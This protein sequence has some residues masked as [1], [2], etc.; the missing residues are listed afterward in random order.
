MENKNLIYF[1]S[2]IK[3]DNVKE[4][5]KIIEQN[6]EFLKYKNQ[7]KENIL[8]YAFEKNSYQIID[9]L[10]KNKNNLQLL[11]DKNNSN[12]NILQY[13]IQKKINIDF[14]LE[15]IKNLNIEQ[16]RQLL[17]SV[18]NQKNNILFLAI[19]YHSYS[20]IISI[21]EE[22]KNFELLSSMKNEKNIYQ[23]N[24]LHFLTLYHN[25]YFPQ[26]VK[27]IDRKMKFEKDD[28]NFSPI[29]IASYKQN[30]ENFIQIYEDNSDFQ[31]ILSFGSYNQDE[32]IMDFLLEQK[33][34]NDFQFSEN[35]HP[36]AIAIIKK[37]IKI[38]PKILKKLNTKILPQYFL[39]L[40]IKNYNFMPYLID[41]IIENYE[42]EKN[43][44]NH[45]NILF[46]SF[47]NLNFEKLIKIMNKNEIN[48]ENEQDNLFKNTIIGKKDMIFKI[49]YL[50]E[51]GLVINSKTLQYLLMLPKNQIE[52]IL[53]KTNILNICPENHQEFINF[54]I[55]YKNLNIEKKELI[56]DQHKKV[57]IEIMNVLTKNCN[58]FNNK[59]QFL[60]I[61]KYLNTFEIS[62]IFFK[63]LY[64]NDSKDILQKI[65]KYFPL[66]ELNEK[67]AIIYEL[68][69][70]TWLH[71]KSDISQYFLKYK[72]VLI[73][74]FLK[75]IQEN[76]IP[77]NEKFIASLKLKKIHFI[78]E[79]EIIN[80]LNSL[81]NIEN[82]LSFIK[83]INSLF[84]EEKL[85]FDKVSLALIENQYDYNIW[86]YFYEKV[87]KQQLFAETF[88]NYSILRKNITLTEIKNFIKKLENKND[89]QKIAFKYCIQD[90]LEI[91]KFN[92]FYN[93][94]EN[95]KQIELQHEYLAN[96]YFCHLNLIKNIQL[97]TYNTK[98]NI[99]KLLNLNQEKEY[100]K[101]LT[102]N[103]NNF[104]KEELENHY[105]QLLNYF[106]DEDNDAI[107]V[108]FLKIAGTKINDIEQKSL[109]K[110]LDN[111]KE[112]DLTF[113]QKL[114]KQY[115][116]D[117]IF[118][119]LIQSLKKDN[120]YLLE[121]Y[122]FLFSK[123]NQI[124]FEKIKL[125]DSLKNKEKNK[126]VVKI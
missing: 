118:Y 38:I 84:Q 31:Q 79:N 29:M 71:E 93:F 113:L 89:I 103:I 43:I 119:E 72:K 91:D 110:L 100:I 82:S 42:F 51:K 22:L 10:L 124:I 25:D 88:L 68:V 23:Q 112:K 99:K 4:F 83:K 107:L 108:N 6:S 59:E 97:K 14:F 18:D 34:I 95:Q 11:I 16:Q 15:K 7:K 39:T 12:I 106:I 44:D 58:F 60:K 41:K 54:I 37:N 67:K 66:F 52:F 75:N 102:D 33:N 96:N 8:F 121:N 73:Q 123:E 50:L 81:S 76:K 3:H 45:R 19:K 30:F 24:I 109:I 2:A 104:S 90:N 28:N 117:E 64:Q 21:I 47:L 126:N 20:N 48:I 46:G 9:F 94:L 69:Q 55:D 101:W 85:Q 27:D 74:T 77:K 78:Q 5:Q 32:K 80:I 92:Y 86:N 26:I 116:A 62:K 1:F 122:S 40:L 65:K 70:N 36:L 53:N 98:L 35:Q 115:H 114:T 13:L 49:N 87:D 105:D 57:K 17:N 111:I 120:F 63:F 125:S 61:K 56:A